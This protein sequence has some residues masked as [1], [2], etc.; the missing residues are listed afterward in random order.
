MTFTIRHDWDLEKGYQPSSS[1]DTQLQLRDQGK[2]YHVN[3]E[4]KE[5][6]AFKCSSGSRTKNYFLDCT[7][8][9][10]GLVGVARGND[11]ST[12][13]WFMGLGNRKR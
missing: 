10:S 4:L 3:V 5:K 1:T 11:Q 12:A 13:E 7:S 6:I 9:L 8:N 2:D